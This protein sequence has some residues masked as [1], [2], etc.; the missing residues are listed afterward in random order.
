[1]FLHLQNAIHVTLYIIRR[2]FI[3]SSPQKPMYS[4]MSSVHGSSV[5]TVRMKARTE[6]PRNK[7]EKNRLFKLR[8][9]TNVILIRLVFLFCFVVVLFSPSFLIIHVISHFVTLFIAQL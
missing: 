9:E 8:K 5:L 1:M 2:A 4:K 6:Q 7:T 3:S